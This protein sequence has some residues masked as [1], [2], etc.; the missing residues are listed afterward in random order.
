[1]SRIFLFLMLTSFWVTGCDLVV[2]A[3]V[4]AHKYYTEE[5][6]DAEK[7]EAEAAKDGDDSSGKDIVI[8][9]LDSNTESGTGNQQTASR[10]SKDWQGPWTRLKNDLIHDTTN[11]MFPLLQEPGEPLHVLPSAKGGNQVDWELARLSGLI[12]PRENLNPAYTSD[13]LDLDIFLDTNGSLPVVRFPHSTH[14]EWIGC[15]SCH[16]EL[17]A[18]KTGETRF[19]M[20]DILNEKACG[21]CHGRVA[22]PL[23]DCFRCHNLSNSR[24]DKIRAR[25]EAKAEELRAKEEAGE[26]NVG[27]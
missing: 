8:P 10:S 2:I 23:N 17:F 27:Q 15:N 3:A 20:I 7:E 16:D 4:E 9:G 19:T 1:M 26:T 21:V 18:M 13:T 5:L 11:P 25:N 12:T 22:F 24:Y 14:T 6:S